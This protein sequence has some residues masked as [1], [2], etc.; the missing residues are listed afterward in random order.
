MFYSAKRN[1][2]F[3]NDMLVAY[4]AAGTLPGDLIEITD[5]EY[6]TYGI[7]SPALGKQCG[8]DA[9]GRPTWVEIPPE[10]INELAQRKRSEIDTSRDAAFAAG[11]EYDIGGTLDVVQ[12]RPQDQINLLGLSTKA[13]QLIA[14]GEPDAVMPFR[15]LSN[16]TRLLTP[17]Q[18]S[19]MTLAAM[20]HIEGIYE[21]SWARKDA[22]TEAL[23][24]GDRKAI[25]AVEW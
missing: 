12:T 15:G 18:V 13:Q 10:P 22:I 2:F 11:L 9:E 25:E 19:E 17:A 24:A 14:T 6:Q 5:Q 4:E 8:P 7:G 20:A 21:R 16:V 3:P 1:Q 23:K